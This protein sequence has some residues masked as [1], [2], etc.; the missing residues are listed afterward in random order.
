[1]TPP[2][3]KHFDL[4]LKDMGDDGTFTMYAA[5]FGNVDRGGDVIEPGAFANLDEFLKDGWIALNH[6]AGDAAIGY[7]MSASQDDKGLLV[8]GRFHS[9][10]EAQVVRTVAKERFDAGKTVKASIGYLVN[11]A[12]FEQRAGR[13][14]R[15]LKSINIHEASFVN[16]PMN[17][18][19]DVVAAKS[20]EIGPMDEQD[21]GLIAALK[22]AIGLDTKK[23]KAIS[24]ANHATLSEHADA[25]DA[26]AK[27]MGDCHKDFKAKVKSFQDFLDGHK[28]GSSP[29]D[30]GDEKDDG[31][32]ETMS[33][34][35]PQ[36][37]QQPPPP[38]SREEVARE[39]AVLQSVDVT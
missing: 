38:P 34:P 33:A 8:T 2:E 11:D 3:H 6:R 15:S 27:A 23:G 12:A 7:P 19:A 10:P 16:L 24:A 28:P 21:T 4:V 1:M 36:S 29:D 13:T 14:V 35:P 20:L 26:S 30:D 5:A 31:E 39:F 32:S 22:R 17:P 9:T 18:A 37:K 25:M